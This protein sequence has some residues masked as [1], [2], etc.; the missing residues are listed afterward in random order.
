MRTIN[1]KGGNNYAEFAGNSDE[2]KPTGV[3]AGSIFVETDT[4]DVYFFDEYTGEWV[5]QFSFQEQ[6]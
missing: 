4:G 1:T 6:E 2:D 3:G 5:F